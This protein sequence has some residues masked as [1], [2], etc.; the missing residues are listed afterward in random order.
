[1]SCRKE[2]ARLRGDDV[3]RYPE[4]GPE[5]SPELEP[6]RKA[7]VLQQMAR[8]LNLAI[9]E[10]SDAETLEYVRDFLRELRE[11]PAWEPIP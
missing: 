11:R 10:W 8:I 9:L 4:G 7:L 2:N 6:T 1:M 5:L 3:R